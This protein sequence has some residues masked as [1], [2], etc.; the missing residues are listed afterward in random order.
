MSVQNPNAEESTE[1]IIDINNQEVYELQKNTSPVVS[2]ATRK[3]SISQFLAPLT[4]DTFKQVV[5][6]VEHKLRI[7]N[8]T[9][10]MLDYQGFETILQEMLHSITLKTGELLGADRTTI[11]LLDEE[12]QE[13]WSI[14]AEG[15]GKRPLEIRIPADKGIAGEVAT[16]KRVVNIPFDF[17]TDERSGFAQ[18]QDKRNGYRTYTMLALPLLNED[19]KL[20]AVVQLLN[21][22]KYVHNPE[23]P[24]CERIDNNGFTSADEKLF[25]DFAPSIRLILESSRS[26]YIATQKQRAAAALMKAIKS[27]SQ[28]SLDLE[29]TLKRVMAEAKELMNADRSTLWLIDRDRNEL[30]TTITQDNGL[31]KEL[32][33]PMGKG[34]AG[35]VAASAKKLNIPFDLYEHPDSE[36]AKAM[37]IQTNFRT[38]SLLCMPVFNS[39]QE[40]IGV[41]Q[42]VN[43]KKLGDFPPY[44]PANWPDAPEC[45]QASFDHNDEEFMEA[46]NIQAG[47]ALQNAQLFAKVKQQEQM[48]R[49]IL[50]SLSNGV[51]SSDK[52]GHII[53]ANES[54]KRLLGF[55]D[56]ERLEGRLVS[57][58]VNIKEGDFSKWFVDALHAT[59][60]KTSQQYYPDRTLLTTSNEQ[61]SINLS[62]NT[63]A[64]ASDQNQVCGALVVMDDISDEKRLKSTMYRYM[65][66]ELAE[67]LLKLDDAKLGGD[68]KEVTILFSDIRGYTTLTENMEAEEVV[69]MLNEYFESMVE[70]VFRHKGTLDKY[71]GDAIM[72]VFGS[73]LP[74]KEHA[75]M[76]VQTSLEM[77][78]RLEE[79]NESR[80]AVN[81]TRIKIGIGINSDT[82]I[83]GNI[84]SS[85]RMEFTAIGDG[86]NLGSR[87]ESVSKQYGCDIIVS[88]NTYRICEKDIWARELDYIR[89]KGRNEPVAIYELLG[90]RS[91]LISDT[92]LELIEH[93]HQGREYYL[94]RQFVKAQS[95]FVKALLADNNDKASMLY[96]GRCQHWIQSPPSDQTWDDGVWTFNE[97]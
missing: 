70:A 13:L 57:D 38:C 43:K 87:L 49:D 25:Q 1:L 53:T 75:R 35:I 33:V 74:L 17:Y 32:R 60:L 15:K 4:Q 64:D 78:S 90:L 85:K 8:E 34:F 95:E 12:N 22:L 68:R 30:W 59:D 62:L 89:V 83:S 9:L 37:D 51:I 79:L 93:Y 19:E 31:P 6:E 46:F 97:K 61:H 23:D 47:V 44:D 77:R 55:D 40:L 54:A 36:T 20:V 65:T 27:L 28:S 94:Q 7:V 71:I 48:Q 58:V 73:P 82:V 56:E 29:D 18:E 26:F 14:L 21:K 39:D 41:T 45:F 24:L 86:V 50:R 11:F 88:D 81:K 63:I 72:A 76:A 10:S 91:D 80:Q 67:E 52:T 5:Q 84:G 92:K 69:G 66:Q 96:L 2:L 16:F 42:L 3:G